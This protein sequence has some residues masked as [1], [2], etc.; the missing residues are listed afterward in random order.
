MD[1]KQVAEGFVALLKENK[2]SEA[3][4]RFWSDDIRSIESAP[5]PHQDIQGREALAAKHAWWD[6]NTEVHGGSV[7]DPIVCGDQFIVTF[8]LDAT[9]KGFGRMQ[10]SETALYTVKDGKIV[11]ERFFY[12]VMMPEGAA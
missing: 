11:E 5:G 8:D 7:G 1:T 10:M 12:P 4:E 6:E 2:D 9:M 3:G